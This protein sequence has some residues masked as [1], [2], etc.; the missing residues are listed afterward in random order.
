[1]KS[2]LRY[3]AL[4]LPLYLMFIIALFPAA[5][6][7]RFGAEALAREMPD[8]KLAMLD[9]SIWSGR[10]GMVAFRKALLG[11]VSW[12]LSPLPLLI[13]KAELRALLQSDDGYL[14]SYLSTPLSGGNLALADI[15]GQLPL[16]ELLRFTPYLPVVLEGQVSLNLPVLELTADGRL[17]RAEGTVMWHQ[18]A[19]S[20]PQVLPLGDLQ[21]V[22]HT[23]AEG[24]LIGEISDR[25]GPLK[26]EGTLQHSP[27][28]S[29][30]LK[31]TVAPA[32]DA[33]TALMQ[34]LV[35][36]G[37]PDTQGRYQLNYSGRL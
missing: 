2:M 34:A 3:L 18:A 5:Q 27:D 25:G 24:E 19:M 6:A 21:L 33:P 12:Q 1:M 8:L 17:L 22:L 31:G 29:Y 28:G 9:G 14:Q 10:A 4:G 32:P 20:A 23:E 13:G 37:K 16:A 15:E 7:Y 35:W 26:V 36:L 30:R 11:E